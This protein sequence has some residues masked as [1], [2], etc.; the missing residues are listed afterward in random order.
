V[1]DNYFQ[2][3]SRRQLT[4]LLTDKT[5][6]KCILFNKSLLT[7]LCQR[8]AIYHSSA[9]REA[10]IFYSLCG[11]THELLN[12]I[13][14]FVS[15]FTIHCSL[16]TDCCFA[17]EPAAIYSDILEY[18]R[19]TSTYNA[20]GNATLQ[21]GNILI[22]ADNITYNET[23]S[24]IV[25]SGN[26]RYDDPEMTFTAG[27]AELNLDTKTGRIFDAAF[28]YRKDNYHVSGKVIEKRGD[29]TFF[30]S[31]ASFTTCDAPSP[32]WC[33]RG[34]N[35]DAVIGE[36]VKAR[37]ISFRIKD[38]P[39]LYAP[40]LWVPILTER[41]TGLLIPAVDFSKSRGLHLNI[42]FF[43]AITENRD[44][45]IILDTYTKRGIGEG[46]EYRYIEPDNRKGKWWLYHIRDTK[47]DRDFVEFRGS[48]EQRTADG[49]G[50]FLNVNLINKKDFY[51]EFS[52][53]SEIRAN[54]FLESTGEAV[55]SFPHSRVYLLSQYWIDL[56]DMTHDAPHKLP[57]A[58]FVLNPLPAGPIL[59]SAS[60]AITNVWREKGTY[61]QRL[62]IYP[63]LFSSFGT[64][65]TV[66]QSAGLRETAYSLNE[67]GKEDRNPHREMLDYTIRTQ[68]S[69]MKK[70]D[71]FTHV[72]EPSVGYLY[73]SDSNQVLPVFDSAELAK[74]TSTID[75]SLLNRFINNNGEFMI[76]RASQGFDSTIGDRPFLP[77]RLEAAI[78]SPV[79]LRLDVSYDAHQGKADSVNSDFSMN[80]SGI[81]LSAGQRYSRID[82]ITF[83][84]AGV[85][86]QPYKS[87]K[88]DGKVWY[89]S[90]D[91][92]I[93]DITVHAKYL[94][95]CWGINMA[96][97]KRPDDYTITLMFELRGLSSN[98]N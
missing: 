67:A 77:F 30:S 93:R 31:D 19:E 79:S 17:R 36:R 57:E 58:G 43:W 69:L 25:A 78:K 26:I 70:F 94:Q 90:I 64:D 52:P 75:V 6:S 9:K 81:N 47:S 24:D 49:A 80:V 15:L 65:V 48:H 21:T 34:K 14:V 51:N 62:D 13:F 74:K 8:E 32:E 20:R 2:G 35:I 4:F 41:Q 96:Y 5:I 28:Y 85:D 97:I 46:L 38:I 3:K 10:G 54:R 12:I 89:D 18:S 44:A 37:D 71:T 68:T 76:I 40:Y 42:P 39:V 86:F 29:K 56:K 1:I 63:K 55:Y 91:N 33:F 60:A 50:G 53:Y 83:Y 22:R 11:F 7:S 95:Q 45:T 66:T 92:E 88:V 16:F 59:V 27:K 72:V 23:T 82:D 84:T 73:Q 87:I 98:R 61:G